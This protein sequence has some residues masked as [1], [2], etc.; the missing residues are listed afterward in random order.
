M[1]ESTYFALTNSFRAVLGVAA[2]FGHIKS[3]FAQVWSTFAIFRSFNW[4]FKKILFALK[5][6]QTDP[7]P[8][9]LTE[10]FAAAESGSKLPERKQKSS[11]AVLA[12]L[13]FIMT[14]PYLLMKL[15]GS[16]SNTALEETRNPRNWLNPVNAIALYDF[17][18]SNQAELSIRT[19]QTVIV[20]PRSVQNTHKLLESG[21]V[22]ATIDGERSGLIPVNYIESVK[23][24]QERR[25]KIEEEPA[26]IEEKI[27]KPIATMKEEAEEQQPPKT[28]L[29]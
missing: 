23:Q 12:F 25:N 19:G 26:I 3:L 6:T 20:A 18:A 5:I 28:T 15:I 9:V 16:V 27:E 11:M 1:L 29:E 24:T 14:A 21:W 13:A 17:V 4:L 2:N 22:M 10:A 8:R 7:G